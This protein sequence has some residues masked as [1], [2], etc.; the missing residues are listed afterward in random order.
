VALISRLICWILS[1]RGI[2]ALRG[3]S[4]ILLL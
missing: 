1:E 4:L 2:L 3:Q